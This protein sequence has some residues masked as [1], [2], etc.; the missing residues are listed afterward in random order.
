MS[1][2]YILLFLLLSSFCSLAQFTLQIEITKKPFSH[3]EE[4]V[5]AAGSFNK[6]NPGDSNYLFKREKNKLVLQ[7]KD[8]AAATYQYKFTRGDWSSKLSSRKRYRE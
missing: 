4:G 5:F 3:Q 8:L 2:I 7:I 1:R 6:W